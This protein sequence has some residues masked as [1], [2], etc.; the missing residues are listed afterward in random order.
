MQ[1]N[2]SLMQDNFPCWLVCNLNHKNAGGGHV[3]G[4][5]A[6][7]DGFFDEP[8]S[9]VEQADS[10]A[11][12]ALYDDASFNCT[13]C[14][15][16]SFGS[17]NASAVLIDVLEIAPVGV[18]VVGIS[19][20]TWDDERELRVHVVESG[21]EGLWRHRG[22]AAD[23]TYARTLAKGILPDVGETCGQS[24]FGQPVAFKEGHTVYVNH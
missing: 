16:R 2:N 1:N 19:A 8:T 12:A 3:E 7:T 10:V 6:M 4:A 23:F 11:H 9:N 14:H 13:D 24:E 15:L 18:S 20:V 21:G 5:G 22:K 17:R